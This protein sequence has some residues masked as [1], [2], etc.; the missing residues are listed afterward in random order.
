M[1]T[2]GRERRTLGAQAIA[3]LDALEDALA[4]A[5]RDGRAGDPLFRQEYAALWSRVRL[6]RFTWLRAVSD[7]ADGASAAMAV[8]KLASS[9][10]QRDVAALGATVHGPALVAGDDAAAWQHRLL[11]APGQ[12]LAGG[13]SEI[14]RNLLAERSLGLPRGPR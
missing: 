7:P 2:L 1:S 8:L 9:E 10:L 3:L 12:R 14:Q 6:L 13:T 5:R 4:T 11:S